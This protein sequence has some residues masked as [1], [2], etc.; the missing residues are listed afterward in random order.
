MLQTGH[1][2]FI[3]M[4][5]PKNVCNVYYD[6]AVAAINICG[7]SV[8]THRQAYVPPCGFAFVVSPN[9]AS[10]SINIARDDSNPQLSATATFDEVR[11]YDLQGNLKK[12]QKYSNASSATINIQGLISGSYIVQI[13]SGTLEEKHQLIIQN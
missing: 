7:T 4:S 10:N 5:I 12:D 1:S 6:I 13:T 3:Q 8:Q 2:T 11:I 9:P